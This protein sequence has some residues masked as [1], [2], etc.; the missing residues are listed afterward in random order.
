MGIRVDFAIDYLRNYPVLTTQSIYRRA[1]AILAQC[2]IRNCSIHSRQ[3]VCVQTYGKTTSIVPR[4]DQ[5]VYR[6]AT[7]VPSRRWFSRQVIWQKD[8]PHTIS[9]GLATYLDK[10][11]YIILK[12]I[13]ELSYPLVL[14]W[15][16]PVCSYY[17]RLLQRFFHQPVSSLLSSGWSNHPAS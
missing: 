10:N 9:V 3:S 17:H 8:E 4:I 2:N 7:V 12:L 1:S 16:D 14:W 6:Y 13:S 5:R 11:I 15:L